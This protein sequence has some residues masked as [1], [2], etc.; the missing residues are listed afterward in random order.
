MSKEDQLLQQ[1]MAQE[2]GEWRTE[3]HYNHY[4]TRGVLDAVQE[5]RSSI[6]LYELKSRC[7]VNNSTGAN[8]II[9]QVNRHREYYFQDHPSR[10]NKSLRLVFTATQKTWD[11]IKNNIQLYAN[12]RMQSIDSEVPVSIMIRRSDGR[13][14]QPAH[15]KA[16]Y[17]TDKWHKNVNY[18]GENFFESTGIEP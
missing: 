15:P 8:E 1:I 2:G 4:G 18:R 13:T 17:H 3:V 14:I 5:I 12:L 10:E 6:N 7:A 11:H 16:G 9:R